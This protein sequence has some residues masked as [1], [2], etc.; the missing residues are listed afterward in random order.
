M[1]ITKNDLIIYYHN[2]N[3]MSLPPVY[4]SE[5]LLPISQQVCHYDLLRNWHLLV[6]YLNHPQFLEALAIYK[7]WS[8]IDD[9]EDKPL[10]YWNTLIPECRDEDTMEILNKVGN[11]HDIYWY[12]APHQCVELNGIVLITLLELAFKQPFYVVDLPGHVLVSNFNNKA[13]TIIAEGMSSDIEGKL[14]FD[15]YHQCMSWFNSTITKQYYGI[16]FYTREDYWKTMNYPLK[17]S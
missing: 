15:L 10:A 12:C 7:W 4:T 16:T 2:R 8:K 5:G 11:K 13:T 17:L 3:I 1:Y 14:I 9:G 6:P